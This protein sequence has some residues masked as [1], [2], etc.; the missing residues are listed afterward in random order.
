MAVNSFGLYKKIFRQLLVG[1]S[2][3][4]KFN[5]NVRTFYFFRALQ[6]KGI[7]Q[8]KDLDLLRY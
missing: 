3:Y 1:T 4:S 6:S 7:T 5:D 2:S 8:Q